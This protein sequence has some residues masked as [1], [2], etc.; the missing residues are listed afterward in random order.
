MN[1][2]LLWTVGVLGVEIQVLLLL[3][4]E[5]SL[6]H[7]VPSR[8]KNHLYLVLGHLEEIQVLL[9]TH[10]ELPR[11]FLESLIK[12]QS[13][14]QPAGGVFGHYSLHHHPNFTVEHYEMVCIC[15]KV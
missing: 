7:I 13:S 11:G 9:Q 14:F 6:N 2:L 3:G 15:R 1:L 12:M 10:Q 5:G 4:D 8:M